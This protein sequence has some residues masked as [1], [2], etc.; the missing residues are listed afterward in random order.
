MLFEVSDSVY[1]VYRGPLLLEF[2]CPK[3]ESIAAGQRFIE[4]LN[5]N[6]SDF[7]KKKS[8]CDKKASDTE[9]LI[10]D[11]LKRRFGKI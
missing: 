1:F 11:C 9:L 5:L 2:S 4:P 10:K 8:V 7:S 3:R 6:D